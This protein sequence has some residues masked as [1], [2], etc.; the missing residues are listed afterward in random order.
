MHL[1]ALA[2]AVTAA[3]VGFDKI[4]IKSEK[5]DLSKG[6]EN[7]KLEIREFITTEFDIDCN[8]KEVL[9]K[10]RRMYAVMVL[11]YIAY[12]KT[13]VLP[14]NWPHHFIVRTWCVPGY[15]Y[16]YGRTD[17]RFMRWACAFSLI[18]FLHLVRLQVY[19]YDLNQ[20]T[21]FSVPY[22]FSF[23]SHEFLWTPIDL[24]RGL[25]WWY[26][27]LI[28]IVFASVLVAARLQIERLH[29]QCDRLRELACT[30]RD[31]D[32]D[33]TLRD[34]MRYRPRKVQ[35]TNAPPSTSD[36]GVPRRDSSPPDS[37]PA[38]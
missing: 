12:A 34:A 22:Y 3:Y 20:E 37:A 19:G 24:R 18:T 7:K 38:Q 36:V 2:V 14:W 4:K 13:R 32:S 25:F 1:G 15:R 28:V 11:C 27:S 35:Q 10:S 29:A 23:E 5:D 21:V 16:F 26:A 9:K 33:H 8:K 6:L 30:Q 17:I 31:A